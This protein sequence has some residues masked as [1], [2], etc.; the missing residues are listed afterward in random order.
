EP[1]NYSS[2]KIS[3]IRFRENENFTSAEELVDQIFEIQLNKDSS[4]V[5]AGKVIQVGSRAKMSKLA[6]DLAFEAGEL[7]LLVPEV[8][9]ETRRLGRSCKKRKH[10]IETNNLKKSRR[11][12]IHDDL[13]SEILPSENANFK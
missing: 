11:E 6:A 1:N 7:S 4:E 8:V 10:G 5:Y 13:T 9:E 2:I 12:A 3:R